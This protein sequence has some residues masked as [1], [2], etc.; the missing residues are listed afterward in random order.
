MDKAVLLAVLSI[1]ILSCVQS[2]AAQCDGKLATHRQKYATFSGNQSSEVSSD[3]WLRTLGT[4]VPNLIPLTFTRYI[5]II[6]AKMTGP[7]LRR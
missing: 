7:I 5:P 4:R 6:I 3:G 1:F 2:G